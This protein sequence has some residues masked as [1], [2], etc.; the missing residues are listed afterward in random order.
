MIAS[1]LVAVAAAGFGMRA[2]PPTSRCVPLAMKV[3]TVESTPNPSAF[4]LR[5]DALMNGVPANE[6]RGETFRK[7]RC[8]PTLAAAVEIEGVSSIFAAGR[9][10]TIS[11]SPSASWESVLPR[12]VEALGGAGE[13][14]AASGSLMPSPKGSDAAS[15]AGAAGGV[16]I[17]LQLSQRLPIQ[18]E[19]SG[20]SGACPPVRA[21]LSARFGSAMA[22]LVEQSSD[23][24]F[25]GR[26]WLDRGPRY[27]DVFDDESEDAA[28]TLSAAD[29]EQRAIATAL[30]EELAEVEAAYPDERLAAIVH[31]S[32]TKDRARP[33]QQQRAGGG[34]ESDETDARLLSLETV[35]ELCDEDAALE[36]AGESTDALR[37]LAAFVTSGGGVAGARRYA[38]AHLGGT[39][40]RGGDVVFDAVAGSFQTEKAAGL[41]RTAG[42]ALSDLG[43]ARAAPLAAAALS[44]RSSLVRWR[45]A[46]ILGEL[47]EGRAVAAALKQAQVH[48]CPW[49]VVHPHA[50]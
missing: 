31:G 49:A 2:A 23:K 15:A 26:A 6:L 7:G 36:S 20:W 24:F 33:Q 11:K 13:E 46:R 18:I 8:P 30:E 50:T 4:L 14:L 48:V 12:V 34:G 40:G 37:R 10:L 17:R 39:A 1:T 43:D 22:L 38:I 44:D 27:P 28:P 16:T 41:R 45:A 25:Q 47:G 32:K 42:D 19:A 9:L 21:K 35:D 29:V 3:V 5:V